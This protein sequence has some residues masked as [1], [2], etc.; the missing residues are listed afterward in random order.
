MALEKGW[1]INI[2]GG[3]HHACTYKGEGFCIYPDITFIV[4]FLRKWHNKQRIMIV[5]LDAHQGNG[6]G[7]DFLVDKDVCIVD[8]YNPYIYPGDI[9]AEQGINTR[10]PVTSY[11]DDQS[12]L[13]KLK[14][15]LPIVIET[16]KPDLIIYNAGTD[17]LINDPLGALNISPQ[18][19]LDRDELM[20]HYALVTYKVPIVMLMSGGY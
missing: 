5:D 9:A 8:A 19:I 15:E 20:F 7:R 13:S 12:Y 4:H 1:A 16:F 17:C 3:F 10:I 2:G 14:A 6:H 11:D 18:G